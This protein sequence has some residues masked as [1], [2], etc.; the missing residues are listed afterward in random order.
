MFQYIRF[1]SVLLFSWS[2]QGLELWKYS[3]VNLIHGEIT[4]NIEVEAPE[5]CI[6]HCLSQPDCKAVLFPSNL[7]G[8]CLEVKSGT[9]F[10]NF[11]GYQYYE[12]EKCADLNIANYDFLLTAGLPCPRLYFPLD[13]DTG[14][15]R[16][17]SKQNIQFVDGGMV[18]KA[19]LNP[20]PGG[21]YYRLGYYPSSEFCFPLP[22][23]CP[24]GITVAFWLKILS[25]TGDRQGILTTR[26]QV[27]V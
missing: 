5:E 24:L 20:L 6:L 22:E 4:E 7:G 25:D 15:R 8:N 3:S 11:T 9:T 21:S 17:P 13:T 12:R 14:T 2:V 23:T 18:G 10:I 16:G 1:T 27:C 19:F 26:E